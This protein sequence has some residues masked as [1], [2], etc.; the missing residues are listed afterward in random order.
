MKFSLIEIILR[1]SIR[2]INNKLNHQ[3]SACLLKLTETKKLK[4]IGEAAAT[5]KCI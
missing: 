3:S 1:I 4:F 5:Q 2:N